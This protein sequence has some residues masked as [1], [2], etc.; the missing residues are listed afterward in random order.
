MADDNII[1][2]ENLFEVLRNE[3]TKEDLQKIDQNFFSKIA[4]YIIEK[5]DSIKG[6]SLDSVER[7]QK[8]YINIRKIVR[9]IF[10]RRESKLIKMALNKARTD[11]KLIST[12]NMLPEEIEFYNDQVKSFGANRKKV[13]LRLLDG[14][15]LGPTISDYKETQAPETPNVPE[16]PKSPE[17]PPT[18]EVPKQDEPELPDNIVVRFMLPV[19][20]FVGKELEVYGPFEKDDVA[21]LPQSIANVLINKGRAVMQDG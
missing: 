19:P 13:L 11:T 2:Y 15:Y 16:T 21:E 1:T 6:D 10:D 20:K 8:E 3:K 5:K 7:S 9:E 12:T 18:P 4:G 17:T 14:E